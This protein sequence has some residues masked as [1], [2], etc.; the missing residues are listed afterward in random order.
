MSRIKIDFNENRS[1]GAHETESSTAL[2]WLK[3]WNA[4]NI[5][6]DDERKFGYG[7]YYYDGRWQ[8]IVSNLIQEFNLSDNSSL[9]DLGCAKGFLVNDFNNDSRVGS[10]EGVD[11]SIYALIEGRKAK[12]NGRLVCANFTALPY[13]NDEFNLIFCKD[14]LHN[15]L[16]KEEVIQALKEITRV[17]KNSWIRVGAY[18]TNAQKKV[19]NNWATFATTYLHK[20]DWLELFDKA[21][22]CGSYDWF[23]PSEI[24]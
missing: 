22:Y 20:E 5:Y 18:E 17:G 19:I 13:E 21:G 1:L 7:G 24:I 10:A 15:I 2:D 8:S 14:S 11:I 23:H 3:V 16:S 6:F 4:D 9:L 12:M